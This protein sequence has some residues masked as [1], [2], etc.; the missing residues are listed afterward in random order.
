LFPEQAA[1]LLS[2]L[3]ACSHDNWLDDLPKLQVQQMAQFG[4]TAA[5]ALITDASCSASRPRQQQ[6]PNL[7]RSRF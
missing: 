2:C 7:H 4:M 6:S 1:D 5:V 3:A